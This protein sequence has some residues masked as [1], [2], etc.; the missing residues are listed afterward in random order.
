MFQEIWPKDADYIRDACLGL[1]I[2]LST[3]PTPTCS[4][5][6]DRATRVLRLKLIRGAGR[7]DKACSLLLLATTFNSLLR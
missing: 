4:H 5:M 7:A 6:M 2:F 3:Q 1:V